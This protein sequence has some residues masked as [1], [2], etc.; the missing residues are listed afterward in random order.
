MIVKA[1]IEMKEPFLP[2]D[3]RPFFV[4]L[5]K[6]AL[7][8]SSGTLFQSLYSENTM[9]KMT[10]SVR[11]NRPAFKR[12]VIEL[13]GINIDLSVSTSDPAFSV[14]LYNSVITLRG[15]DFPFLNK[16]HACVRRVSIE[17]H[18]AINADSVCV[19]FI[20]PLVLRSHEKGK[21]D[22]YST[23]EDSNFQERFFTVVSEQL[24]KLHGIELKRGELEIIPLNPFKTVSMIFGN[25]IP[26]SL[27]SYEIRADREVLNV[28]YQDGAGSRRSEGCGMFE[29][30]RAKSDE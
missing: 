18:K 20:S 6:K 22:S 1:M 14:D 16:H 15:R 11:L 4:S 3:N 28:L 25:M 19:K 29:I 24:K 2:K 23:F 8:E 30:V 9:K 12:D 7:S 26:C 13:G 17:N 21:R 5:I 10:F 27:G